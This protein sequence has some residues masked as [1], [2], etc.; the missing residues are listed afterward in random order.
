[1]FYQYLIIPSILIFTFQ[2][3]LKGLY[4][5][6]PPKFLKLSLFLTSIVA[7]FDLSQH[8]YQSWPSNVHFKLLFSYFLLWVPFYKSKINLFKVFKFFLALNVLIICIEI[9][10]GFIGMY[11]LKDNTWAAQFSIWFSI[12][13]DP[14]Q[15]PIGQYRKLSELVYLYRPVGLIGNIHISSLAIFFL[16]FLIDLEKKP[17]QWLKIVFCFFLMMLCGTIQSL[18]IFLV[19]FVISRKITLRT[20][21]VLMVALLLSLIVFWRVIDPDRYLLE[22]N[23]VRI[24]LEGPNFLNSVSLSTIFWGKDIQLVIPLLDNYITSKQGVNL[25]G[26]SDFAL[27][28]VMLNYGFIKLVLLFIPPIIHMRKLFLLNPSFKPIALFLALNLSLLHY[29]MYDSFLIIF[30]YFG[31]SSLS[32]SYFLKSQTTGGLE[33]KIE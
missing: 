1:M 2:G 20:S 27:A 6:K 28:R 11:W 19:Y 14:T 29:W 22:L 12:T 4:E 3:V 30:L 16:A 8:T 25:H 15:T 5:V 31:L 10:L 13:T 9:I 7:L 24:I 26:L 21:G 23:I 17:Y 33:T 18:G 32:T